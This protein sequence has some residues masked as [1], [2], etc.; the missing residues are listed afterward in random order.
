M[1]ATERHK[2][3]AAIAAVER[4]QSGQ[5]VG[6]GTGSTVRYAIEELGE[7]LRQ[8]RLGDVVGIPT[9]NDTAALAARQGIPLTE[10]G[11]SPMALAIDGA[12]EI[13]PALA[14][15]KGGGGISIHRDRR[16]L[17]AGRPS[18]VEL[19]HSA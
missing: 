9:S 7:R 6:L 5:V 3:A 4:I 14:L 12:D 15:T 8:G 18:R 17:E 11:H 1:A 13:T 16:R 19:P 2:K 10:V